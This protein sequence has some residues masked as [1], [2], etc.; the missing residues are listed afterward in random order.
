MLSEKLF[1]LIL[2]HFY[3]VSKHVYVWGFYVGRSELEQCCCKSIVFKRLRLCYEF[4]AQDVLDRFFQVSIIDLHAT[5]IKKEL[6][7]WTVA[8][9]VELASDW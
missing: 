6:N 9:Q 7:T 8:A 5:L 2:P 3:N 1:K 4:D